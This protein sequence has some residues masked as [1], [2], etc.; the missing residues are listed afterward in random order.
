MSH[1]GKQEVCR[2]NCPIGTQRRSLGHNW[3]SSQ[4]EEET[5]APSAEREA[6]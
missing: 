6:S 1:N 3:N 4:F 5:L 2:G